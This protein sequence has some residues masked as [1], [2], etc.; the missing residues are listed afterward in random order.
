MSALEDLA[1]EIQPGWRVDIT[2]HDYIADSRDDAEVTTVRENAVELTPKRPWSSQGRNF[3]STILT[4]DDKDAEVSG[5]TVRLYHTPPPHT[6]KAR[7][8]ITT[9]TFK[10]PRGF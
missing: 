6:G 5:R 3:S 1:K 7:R 2:D 9:Y 4:W 10:P 8:L